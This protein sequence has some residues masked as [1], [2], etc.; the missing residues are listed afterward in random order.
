MCWN[1]AIYGEKTS[2]EVVDAF[3]Y[4]APNVLVSS[5]GI[6]GNIDL[7]RKN[8]PARMGNPPKNMIC[9][10]PAHVDGRM[11]GISE[12]AGA[13]IIN[14]DRMWHYTEG[15]KNWNSIWPNHGIRILPG[16]SSIWL[17]RKSPARSVY[18]RV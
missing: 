2:R 13:N 15:I 16:P 3:H 17:E 9:G 10:V 14:P 11:I 4:E 12:C 6:G 8:W 5:G 18:A 7:V 1:Q